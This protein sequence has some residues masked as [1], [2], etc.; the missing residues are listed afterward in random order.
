M[1]ASRS[2]RKCMHGA[3]SRFTSI[4]YQRERCLRGGKA[5]PRALLGD[6][7]LRQD[8][9]RRPG[10]RASPGGGGHFIQPPATAAKDDEAAALPS[11]SPTTSAAATRGRIYDVSPLRTDSLPLVSKI[12]WPQ[13]ADDAIMDAP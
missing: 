9:P 8:P 13:N 12:Y 10:R 2:S 7:T 5:C 1:R 3:E 4:S 6:A 11:P